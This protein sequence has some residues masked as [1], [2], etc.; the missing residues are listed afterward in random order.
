MDRIEQLEQNL[1]NL[2]LKLTDQTLSNEAIS[3][4]NATIREI[5]QEICA[6]KAVSVQPEA[7]L[8]GLP[9]RRTEVSYDQQG[10]NI[11]YGKNKGGVS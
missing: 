8:P 2:K 4:I 3:T 6:L 1:S 11:G 10:A 5:D 9:N 7:T